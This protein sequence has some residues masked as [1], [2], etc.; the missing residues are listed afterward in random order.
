MTRSDAELRARMG[1]LSLEAKVALLT[2]ADMWTTVESTAAGLDAMVTSD[3]PVGI[4]G[5]AWDERVTSPLLPNPSAI[6]ANWDPG[7][8]QC[9]GRILGEQAVHAGVRVALAPVVNLHRSPLGGRHFEC[10]SEDPLLTARTA[11]AFITGVQSC[12]VAAAVKHYV[13]NESE[14]DRLGY[15]AHIDERA[16]RE[17]YLAPFE[18]AVREA[19]VWLV[20]AAYNGV[21][22]P[23]MTE[24]RRLLTDVLKAEWGFDGVVISDWSATRSTE[25]SALAGLDLVMPGPG[26]PWGPAL[27]AAVRAGRVPED[28]V[29]NKVLRLLRLADRVGALEAL[30]SEP[31]SA[32]RPAP[33]P[34]PA[35]PDTVAWRLRALA[36]GGAVLLRNRGVLPLGTGAAGGVALIGAHAGALTA[37]GGGSAHVHPPHVV[38]LDDALRAALGPDVAVQVCPGVAYRRTLPPVPPD[39]LTEPEEGTP[40]LRVAFH[41]ATGAVLGVQQRRSSRL[42]FMPG[43]LPGGTA[44][45]VVT[46]HFTAGAEGEHAF[47]LTGTG[48]LRLR[49]GEATVSAGAQDGPA[50]LMTALARPPE[51]RMAVALRAGQDVPVE[52]VHEVA[53]GARF[54]AFGFGVRPPGP[55]DDGEIEAAVSAARGADVA[56]V[57]VGTGDE[58]ESEGFDRDTL[59]LPGRQDELVERVAAVNSRT[60]VVVNAGA[61]VLMP[62]R[63]RVDAVLWAWLPGQEGGAAI[64]DVLTGAA[65]PGGRLPTTFPAREADAPVLGTE[66]AGGVVDYAESTVTGYLAY[67]ARGIAPAYPFGHGLGYT[68]WAYEDAKA[69]AGDDG[70]AEV[71]VTVRNTG[72]REGREVVQCYLADES[73]LMPVAAPARLVGF[74]AVR[75]APGATVTAHL[76]VPPRALARYDVPAAAWRPPGRPVTLRI[77]RSATDLP[78]TA[79]IE[80]GGGAAGEAGPGDAPGDGADE[81]AADPGSAPSS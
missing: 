32:V 14:T 72:T 21:N 36:T 9:A 57:V 44:R 53:P 29:D 8:A 46:A 7:A 18:A 79:R 13:G 19:G 24:H 28:L 38:Q 11:V 81:V 35:D 80:P 39:R 69:V 50:G 65:E 68:T 37:Q 10:F 6:A 71:V 63:D 62:W 59:A 22:G 20:M 66:P 61:P 5:P 75:A 40:G 34:Q 60:V 42:V 1:G 56:I 16:L 67:A 33:R 76:T 26:G 3:G 15:V 30:P 31:V 17:L 51:Q 74:E 45:V 41:D 58:V 70:G 55:G 12:G 25:A 47:G 49:V 23:T 48:P 77:G 27:V 4:R 52:L 73:V 54:A 43:D 64:A 78:L 2:G